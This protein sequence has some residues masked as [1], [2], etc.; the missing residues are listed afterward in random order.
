MNSNIERTIAQTERWLIALD[1]QRDLA[2][3]HVETFGKTPSL[4]SWMA[5]M[6][7][8]RYDVLALLARLKEV[9]HLACLILADRPERD[10]RR[11]LKVPLRARQHRKEG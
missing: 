6:E 8:E 3:R 7:K 9:R 4:E 5:S 11:Q 1:E 2:A 10:I